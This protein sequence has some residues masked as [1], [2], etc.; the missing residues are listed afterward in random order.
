MSNDQQRHGTGSPDD[1]RWRL[2]VPIEYGANV[3]D[4]LGEVGEPVTWAIGFEN[5]RWDAPPD[6]SMSRREFRASRGPYR[7]SVPPHIADLPV[8]LDDEVSAESAEAAAE[9]VRFDAELSERLGA[10]GGGELS[11]LAA[12][13]LRTESASWMVSGSASGFDGT[14]ESTI[15]SVSESRNTSL[16]NSSGPR[17]RR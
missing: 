10:L 14:K 6:P 11:P 15:I 12:V 13:L 16:M 8:D 5:L 7:A 9:L 4:A 3:S 17:Q 1:D 2:A